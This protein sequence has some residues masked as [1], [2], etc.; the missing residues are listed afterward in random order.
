[1]LPNYDSYL[2]TADRSK[3]LTTD[4]QYVCTVHTYNTYNCC[5]VCCHILTSRWINMQVMKRIIYFSRLVMDQF[6][7]SFGGEKHSKFRIEKKKKFRCYYLL[8]TNIFWFPG[9][10]VVVIVATYDWIDDH[11]EQTNKMW[12]KWETIIQSSVYGWSYGTWKAFGKYAALHPSDPFFFSFLF[13]S[14]VWFSLIDPVPK[15]NQHDLHYNLS[16]CLSVCYICMLKGWDRCLFMYVH[17]TK[18][19]NLQLSPWKH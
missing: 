6:L 4:M 9:P 17:S 5:S 1:M 13:F 2:M 10:F 14:N 11:Q 3:V 8:P 12:L 19:R 7:M 16:Y 18:Q 15:K